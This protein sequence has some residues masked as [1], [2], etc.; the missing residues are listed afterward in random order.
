M[1]RVE[2]VDVVLTTYHTLAAGATSKSQGLSEIE[3]F[4]IV[5]D[6]GQHHYNDLVN[7]R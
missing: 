1:S 2:D 6:E 7:F 5:L 4:R 3:W